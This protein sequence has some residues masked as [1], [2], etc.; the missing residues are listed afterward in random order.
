ML[1]TLLPAA[2]SGAR[3]ASAASDGAGDARAEPL[4]DVMLGRMVAVGLP[5]A[6]TVASRRFGTDATFGEEIAGRAEGM[7][8]DI[9]GGGAG[10]DRRAAEEGTADAAEPAA[11]AVR[12]PRTVA[13]R[14]APACGHCGRDPAEEGEKAFLKCGGC[15]T[16]CFC[17]DACRRA[18]W[19]A[20]HKTACGGR[21]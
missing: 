11:R 18:A 12:G 20:G 6:I 16:V 7:L 4:P 14:V 1:L 5:V 15:R 21:G 3:D 9:R 19:K 2:L 17:G 8:A 13:E 10:G